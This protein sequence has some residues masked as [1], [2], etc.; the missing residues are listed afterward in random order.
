[1]MQVAPKIIN[2]RAS[3]EFSIVDIATSNPRNR[4]QLDAARGLLIGLP[5]SALLWATIAIALF[6]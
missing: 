6:A 5:V 2:G 3:G 4:K 1:M